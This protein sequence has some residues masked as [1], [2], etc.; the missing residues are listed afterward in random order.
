MISDE[1]KE[2]ESDIEK[3]QMLKSKKKAMKD[4]KIVKE[5][6]SRHCDNGKLSDGHSDVNSE[7]N[8]DES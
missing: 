7:Y 8:S 4:S 5:N 2:S 6:L 3:G 1:N